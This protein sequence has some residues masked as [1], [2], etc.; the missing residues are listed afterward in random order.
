MTNKI[1]LCVIS[2]LVGMLLGVAIKKTATPLFS[3]GNGEVE[4][5]MDE[6]K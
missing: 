5:K 4:L 1:A 2:L 3:W 6:Y